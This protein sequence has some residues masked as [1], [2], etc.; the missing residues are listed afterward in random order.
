M[1]I[2]PSI[3]PDAERVLTFDAT[4]DLAQGPNGPVETLQGGITVNVTLTAGI[5]PNPANIILAPPAYGNGG[6]LMLQ[7]VGNLSALVGNDYMLEAISPTTTPEKVVVIRGLLQ[8]RA[9]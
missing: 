8:V 4:L 9:D 5:D 1:V 7:P 2:F 6:L 3:D